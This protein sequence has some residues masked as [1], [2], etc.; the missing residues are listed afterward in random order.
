MNFGLDNGGN[1]Q[2]P[3]AGAASAFYLLHL[4]WQNHQPSF[5]DIPKN[6]LEYLE[7]GDDLKKMGKDF[8]ISI[9]ISAT[10]P[11]PPSRRI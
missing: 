11:S 3:A 5:S 7:Y 10:S 6:T 1:L 2:I 8:Y 9:E 4:K